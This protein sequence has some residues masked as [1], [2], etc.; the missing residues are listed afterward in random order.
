M[1]RLLTALAVLILLPLAVGAQGSAPFQ[2]FPGGTYDPAI[3]TPESYLGYGI[4]ERFTF[5]H[6]VKGYL[7]TVAAASDRV[8]IG[9]YGTS[10]EGRELLLLTV[11]SP[12]NQARIEQVRA[13]MARLAD[14]RGAS[15][16]E[17]QR[18]IETS[19]A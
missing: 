15:E 4:G 1:R 7:E 12:A 10:N 5:H 2:W 3:P 8:T 19:P 17:L 14:P 11:T 18:I 6:R 16:T 9:T 13:D